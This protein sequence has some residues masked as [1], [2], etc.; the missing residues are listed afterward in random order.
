[1]SVVAHLED[2]LLGRR[3]RVREQSNGHHLRA[4]VLNTPV[5]RQPG[6]RENIEP[7]LHMASNIKHPNVLDCMGLRWAGEKAVVLSVDAPDF[8]PLSHV[9]ARRRKLD[10]PQ[11]IEILGK[12]ALALEEAARHGVVHGWLRP[13]IVLVNAAG[14]VKVDDLAIPKA[15]A[16]LVRESLG[17]SAATEHYLAPEYLSP[18]SPADIRTDVFLLG[19]LL[20]R[21]ITGEGLVTGYNAYEALHKATSQGCRS[22]R[23]VNQD[24]SLDLDS[25]CSRMTAID[26]KDR[27]DNYRELID[28]IEAFGGGA[29]R[30][31]MRL[32]RSLPRRRTG[33][34]GPI[35]RRTGGTGPIPRRAGGTGPIQHHGSTGT[36]RHQTTGTQRHGRP[37]TGPIHRTTGTT[38][39]TH[40]H[41][42]HTHHGHHE[43]RHKQ[44]GGNG[45]MVGAVIV[46]LLVF[47]GVLYLVAGGGSSY[48]L[49]GG[50]ATPDQSRDSDDQQSS[51]PRNS[52]APGGGRQ[53]QSTDDGTQPTPRG[54]ASLERARAL[55]REL[56]AS[57]EDLDLRSRA[58][59]AVRAIQTR[60][61]D[62]FSALWARV[63]SA[64]T[65]SQSTSPPAE[66]DAPEQDQQVADTDATPAGQDRPTPSED[67]TRA[68]LER[69]IAEERFGAA[70]RLATERFAD[71]QH[72]RR[73]WLTEIRQRHADARSRVAAEAV[74]TGSTRAA[75]TLLDAAVERWQIQ[76]DDQWAVTVLGRLHGA[77]PDDEQQPDAG[78]ATS[79]ATEAAL[80]PNGLP[81]ALARA[82]AALD[83]ALLRN[84]DSAAAE[85]LR[86]ISGL[87]LDPTLA[88]APGLKLELWLRRGELLQQ[89]ID[90]RDPRLPVTSP[91]DQTS[92]DVIGA[93]RRQLQISKTS[94]ATMGM[95]WSDVPHD[96]L[97]RLF[98]AA[99]VGEEVPADELALACIAN[100]LSGQ[101][102]KAHLL[103][104][105]AAEAGFAR[106]DELERL[107]QLHRER[108]LLQLLDRATKALRSNDP[109]Q[110]A[111]AIAQLRKA[112]GN[113]PALEPDIARLEKAQ[114]QL[115]QGGTPALGAGGKD[116]VTFGALDDLE[117]FPQRDGSWSISDGRLNNKSDASLERSDCG[118]ARSL[119]IAFMTPEQTG[120]MTVQFRG[121]RLVIDLTAQSFLIDSSQERVPP[122][123]FPFLPHTRHS[124]HLA[125]AEDG[126]MRIEINQ[127]EPILIRHGKLTSDLSIV[128]DT[129]AQI[130]IDEIEIRRLGG[131]DG[132]DDAGI[133]PALQEALAKALGLLPLGGAYK[134]PD[135]PAIVLPR[136]ASGM[137]GIGVP[138]RD[139]LR[140]VQF[141]VV[142]QGQLIVGLG[143]EVDGQV[144]GELQQCELPAVGT[145][146]LQ[147][148]VRWS[149]PDAKRWE[150]LLEMDNAAPNLIEA[151]RPAD[152][153]H[154]FIQA[155]GNARILTSPRLLRP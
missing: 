127:A 137:S 100:L 20:F 31:T 104:K 55:V 135:S 50:T 115:Q 87:D 38:G 132:S 122:Q 103:S 56:E 40:G 124:L 131:D 22:L 15:P 141:Q 143:K 93:D 10:P 29:H 96:E 136:I 92:W 129:G 18:D 32:T 30:G 48:L 128:T 88:A 153:T 80:T 109:D 43:R 102:G 81:V 17:G 62:D 97:G 3:V 25:F 51:T 65:T 111:D 37:G 106:G 49:P 61:P 69:L 1:M 23:S 154:V 98:S 82:D 66:E 16:Y 148:T 4:L 45:L 126:R 52:P 133:D 70:G 9:L 147:V 64:R 114:E 68:E 47:G 112:A 46:L 13:D 155:K 99:V 113:N 145:P 53:A 35:P 105:R 146:G 78:P 34:T 11:A 83:Q 139:N 63:N 60:H 123:N 33:G 152:A 77:N 54:P 84:D 118:N 42:T 89:A 76:G 28:V 130:G 90:A 116:H 36:R 144:T 74:A 5:L 142:G 59:E 95:S 120:G 7:R 134:D 138:I 57:P 8:E 108:S 27:Y 21:M 72:V 91:I 110:L 2:N 119:N 86:Q 85:A 150:L 26:R 140:G 151:D 14:E 12:V 94:G 44:Q 117:A 73:G 107:I 67:E 125:L 24:I 121:V 19:C 79:G 75:R 101:P 6:Y 41:H 71:R 58:R 149:G 39:T